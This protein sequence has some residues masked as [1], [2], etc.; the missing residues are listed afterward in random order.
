MKDF[1]EEFERFL[2]EKYREPMLDAFEG[3]PK[4]RSVAVDY[5]LLDAFDP[6]LAKKLQENPDEMIAA[7][8]KAVQTMKPLVFDDLRPLHI[9]IFNLPKNLETPIENLADDQLNKLCQ[10]EGV[11]RKVKSSEFILKI[12]RWQCTHC[13]TTLKTSTDKTNIIEPTICQCGWCDFKLIDK[14]GQSEFV[15]FQIA[16]LQETTDKKPSKK[17]NKLIEIHLEDDLVNRVTP[18]AKYILTGILRQINGKH[19]KV[20]INQQVKYLDIIHLKQI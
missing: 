14:P 5:Q 17:V 16:Q 6:E 3:Y 13:Q 9:R 11:I 20:K 12:A 15:N 4:K 2:D 10:V 19:K 7:A 1:V 18:G 8:E